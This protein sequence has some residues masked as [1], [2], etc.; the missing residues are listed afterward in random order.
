MRR[1]GLLRLA[2]A[3]LFSCVLTASVSASAYGEAPAFAG[4]EVLDQPAPARTVALT[5][6]DGATV[7][8]DGAPVTVLNFWA[9]WCA[10][11][12][13]ELPTLLA[14]DA[15][16]GAQGL[17]V[18]AA[19]LDRNYETIDRFWTQQGWGENV[20]VALD[21]KGSLFRDFSAEDLGARGVP[22]TAILNSN[23]EIISWY[24][25]DAD[26]ASEPVLAYFQ[27]VLDAGSQ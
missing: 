16:L 4:L 25:G 20:E 14:L 24:A 19:S 5:D 11:C 23:G 15:Q 7:A 6:R 13:A 2:G 21:D 8:L 26:W 1:T 12:V 18:V 3:G 17:R 10:P 9:T 27:G 22:Y